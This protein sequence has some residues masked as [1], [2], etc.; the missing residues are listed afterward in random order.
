MNNKKTL[1]AIL[2]SAV[3]GSPLHTW[4][5]DIDEPADST[6]NER[7][8]ANVPQQSV[9]D[10][11]IWVVGDEA[12]YK[13]D[14]EAV[15]MQSEV[16]GVKWNGDPDCA[17]P[18]QIAVQKLFLHQA[19]L[20]SI[21]VSESDVVSGVDD[22]INRWVQIAGSQ[23]KL[24]EYRKQSITEMRLSL[25]DEFKNNELVRQM[26]QKLVKNVSVTPADVRNYFKDM[27]EDSIP[28]VPTE[29]EVQIITQQPRFALPHWPASIR[30]TPAQPDREG[31]SAMWGAATWT[32]PSLPWPSTSPTRRRSRRWWSRSS[33]ST[34]FSSSTDAAT[35]SRC[36]TSCAN[37]RFHART[38]RKPCCAWTR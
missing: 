25:H 7:T 38:W 20:D 15:R 6:A 16:E 13:S 11:V 19:A 5:Q 18:E 3:L 30:K 37:R 29:V 8:I 1:F 21:E 22:Q 10:E 31:S 28:F 4:A 2:L 24:E 12:I 26:K 34:S 14:V 32:L 27:P 9:I 23:E 17:I 36:A 35:A 33:D